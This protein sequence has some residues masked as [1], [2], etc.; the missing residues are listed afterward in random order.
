MMRNMQPACMCH[1]KARLT[2]QDN[3]T[4]VLNGGQ[5]RLQSRGK[6]FP[7]LLRKIPSVKVSRVIAESIVVF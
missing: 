3:G 2:G 6:T 1:K 5:T 7:K 4:R